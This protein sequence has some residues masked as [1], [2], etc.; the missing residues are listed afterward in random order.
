MIRKQK[1]VTLK[2]P[3]ERAA[4]H[5]MNTAQQAEIMLILDK[6]IPSRARLRDRL[7]REIETQLPASTSEPP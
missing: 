3:S 1:P 7:T 2:P 6:G 4:K 5:P